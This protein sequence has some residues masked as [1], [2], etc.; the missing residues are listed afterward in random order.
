MGRITLSFI[1]TFMLSFS[2]PVWAEENEEQARL[3]YHQGETYLENGEFEK[4]IA[5]YLEGHRLSE[6]SIFLYNVA[7]VYIR[8]NDYE[9][10]YNYLIRYQKTLPLKEQAE[11]I[12]LLE[13]VKENLSL[14]VLSTLNG[15][16]APKDD[17]STSNEQRAEEGASLEEARTLVP[18][19]SSTNRP[20]L[21]YGSLGI[22]AVS[23]TF[24]GYYTFQSRSTHSQLTTSCQGS[25]CPSSVQPLIQQE[26]VQALGADIGLGIGAVALG[27]GIVL[28]KFQKSPMIVSSNGNS[29]SF[30][31]SF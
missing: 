10:A 4:A 8:I 2:H 1:I 18:Q 21:A 27:A 17:I 12:D 23:A 6:K 3:L 9:S 16:I 11:I 29:I 5:A 28:L 7:V 24:G 26:R 30:Q 22:G 15:A 14:E 31:G 13:S 20:W 19:K 25:L